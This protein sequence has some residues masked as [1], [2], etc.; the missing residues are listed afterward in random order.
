MASRA[1]G[2]LRGPLLLVI[3]TFLMIAVTLPV[4]ARGG[5]GRFV[6][7]DLRQAGTRVKILAGDIS[8]Y[9]SAKFNGTKLA[10]KC[11]KASGQVGLSYLLIPVSHEGVVVLKGQLPSG[12]ML[13]ITILKDMFGEPRMSIRTS[14]G[15][16]WG[17]CGTGG[18]SFYGAQR[19]W[20]KVIITP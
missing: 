17:W 9:G 4:P 15:E 11:L 18:D 6:R 19:A 16:D 3:A 12:R 7:A 1:D 14:P 13:W 2:R 5:S 20:G 10:I 8:P